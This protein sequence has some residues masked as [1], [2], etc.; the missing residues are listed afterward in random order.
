MANSQERRGEAVERRSLFCPPN[1]PVGGAKTEG[2][3]R[4]CA[5]GRVWAAQRVAVVGFIISAAISLSKHYVSK[6]GPSRALL[7]HDG[8]RAF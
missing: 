6:R 8:S 4:V 7:Y 5:R 1:S 2:G 3:V